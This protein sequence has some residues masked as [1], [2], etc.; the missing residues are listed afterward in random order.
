MLDEPIAGRQLLIA[1]T[2][3]HL[4]QLVK[5]SKLIGSAPDSLWVTFRNPQS[6]SLL[7]NERVMYVDYV[8]SRD[9]RGACRAALQ[10]MR[11]ID[12]RSEMFT[13]AISTGS[14]VGIAG[15][16][17]ARLHGAPAFYFETVSRVNGPTL[18][19]KFASRIPTIQTY[20]QYEGWANRR[21][22]YRKSLLDNYARISS[23]GS[24]R[25]RLLVTLGTN[26]TYRFDAL[27]DA[28]LAT[29]LANDDTVWQL[30]ITTRQGLPG[31]AHHE[32]PTD[33]LH[34]YAGDADVVVTHAGVGTLIDL[35]DM[36]IYPVVVPRRAKRGEVVDDHQLQIAELLRQRDIALVAEA[37][38]LTGQMLIEASGQAVQFV[39]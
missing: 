13:S 16:V 35:L 11:R 1:S 19:G 21:W 18:S 7:H 20:C 9:F 39:S 34:R 27:V 14:A 32:L 26:R 10:M 28:V 30:G 38:Q 29:G 24:Q 15:L 22:K 6:E 8:G 2:G 23:A 5:W 3:G 12:W 36:G 33:E 4:A 31:T 25:P 37:E 17:A